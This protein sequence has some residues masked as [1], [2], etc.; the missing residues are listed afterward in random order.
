VQVDGDTLLLVPTEQG[1]LTLQLG[2]EAL[3]FAFDAGSVAVSY[4]VSGDAGAALNFAFTDVVT[5][6]GTIDSLTV[7]SRSATSAGAT[8]DVG[9]DGYNLSHPE[10][11]GAL[12]PEIAALYAVLQQSTDGAPGEFM[13]SDLSVEWG[14]LRMTGAGT[15]A[16]A[17][18]GAWSGRLD[19]EIFD[20]LAWLDA[21]RAT[22]PLD[23]DA[24]AETYAAIIEEMGDA[25]DPETLPFSL[26]IN[27]GAV[28]LRGEPRGIPDLELG[29]IAPLLAG[30]V[31]Q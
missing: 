10:T 1:S 7:V 25:A 28:T 18:S 8:Y 9:I 3:A 2:A 31:I 11:G 4:S 5:A 22:Q 24:M 23:L 26:R 20:P 14:T 13:V 21:I 27:D 17:E 16:R 15:L 30:A 29:I 6:A 12:G 19:V